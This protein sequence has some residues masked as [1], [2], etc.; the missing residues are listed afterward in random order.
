MVAETCRSA[1]LSMPV[2]AVRQFVNEDNVIGRIHHQR[3]AR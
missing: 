3:C 1:V 2:I